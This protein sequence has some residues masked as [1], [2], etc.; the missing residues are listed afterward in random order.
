[1]KI[2]RL[3]SNIFKRSTEAIMPG[4]WSAGLFE[5]PV[6]SGISVNTT[7][8]QNCSVVLACLRVLS[9]SV[10]SLPLKVYQKRSDKVREEA[11]GHPLYE[12]FK[13]GPNSE[14]TTMDWLEGMMLRM[15]LWGR[16]YSQIIYDGGGRVRSIH[17]LESKSMQVCRLN[18]GALEYVY[19]DSRGEQHRFPQSEILDIA[20]PMGGQSLITL[21]RESIGLAIGA[22]RYGAKFFANDARPG[23]VLESP[24]DLSDD[25]FER[26]K[27]EWNQAH[28]GSNNANRMAILE[29]GMTWKQIG[30]PPDA[31]QFLGT[32]K[33]QRSDIAGWFRI[34][35][36]LIGDLERATFTNI[37]HQGIEFVVHTI[38]PWLIRI[39]QAV[40]KKFLANTQ[41]YSKFTVDALLRGDAVA[42]ADFYSRMRD[43]GLMNAN[44]IRALEDL[45]PLPGKQGEA[46]TIQLNMMNL[47]EVVTPPEELESPSRQR[48]EIRAKSAA[49]RLRLREAYRPKLKKMAEKHLK[50]EISDIRAAVKKH[51]TERDIGTFRD[52]LED[53][54]R[55]KGFEVAS[56]V[57]GVIR[58]YADAA[59]EAAA[60]EVAG[61]VP[62]L[63]KF[64]DAY[65][66]NY[67]I[68]H[69]ATSKGRLRHLE[70]FEDVENRLDDWE[71]N[72]ADQIANKEKVGIGDA[73]A[74]VVF[75]FVGHELMWQ[76]SSNPCPYC[77]QLGGKIVGK[78]GAFVPKGG[79]V[80]SGDESQPSL[81]VN[82]NITHP[83]L[84]GGCECFI[85]PG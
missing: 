44:E 59:G 70:S 41:Y 13:E 43:R 23:G 67:G 49:T 10:A 46:Y 55:E 85:V 75:T 35:P 45:N 69:A 25:A 21:A 60:V 82:S 1:M 4:A 8:A 77:E 20:G 81:Q 7:T 18:S 61:E 26:L 65:A 79:S 15:P 72:R 12:L 50:A 39:E 31:A 11:P 22:E 73:V 80:D 16:S 64:V 83:P 5:P 32:R 51:N 36:H 27:K 66:K 53:Y 76:T 37:E 30:I 40:N 68:R 29:Q 47:E 71:E 57:K 2:G 48:R 33:Y 62:D 9:E 74:A 34:P 42:R 6:A 3:L 54:Y 24:S 78:E 84:H 38:R 19:I 52:F 14:M 56:D 17:L 58:A 28:S 63:D